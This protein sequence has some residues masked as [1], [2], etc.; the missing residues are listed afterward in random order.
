MC[1]RVILSYRDVLILV[2]EHCASVVVHV[3]VI[4]CRE[5]SDHR[6]KPLIRLFVD[7]VPTRASLV[8][9]RA[10]TDLKC[11]THPAS[12]ASCPRMIPSRWFLSK[13]A[14]APA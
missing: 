11:D 10:S 8:N 13:N 2:L 5:D 1:A 9:Q 4:R 7:E 12:C 14:Q 6:W 3:K